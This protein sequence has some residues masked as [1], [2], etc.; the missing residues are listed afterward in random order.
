M[1]W[2]IDVFVGMKRGAVTLSRPMISS[3]RLA[4]TSLAFML[5]EVPAPPWMMSTTNWSCN[6]PAHFFAGLYDRLGSHG[7]QRAERPWR[8]RPPA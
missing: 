1:L 7:V 2:Q 3:A 8:G 5:V 6:E 4:I